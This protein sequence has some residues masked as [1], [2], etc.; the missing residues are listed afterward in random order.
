MTGLTRKAV[1]EIT[2]LLEETIAL[3]AELKGKHGRW[4][5]RLHIYSDMY[6]IT[7]LRVC[8]EKRVTNCS[9]SKCPEPKKNK[10]NAA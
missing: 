1:P 9:S 10:H 7:A 4:C 8:R 6:K 3:Q 2:A 5:P